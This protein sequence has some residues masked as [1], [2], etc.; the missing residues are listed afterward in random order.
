MS[1]H[2]WND[3]M[4]GIEV[5]TTS[6]DNEKLFAFVQNHKDA[7]AEY[8][9]LD[10]IPTTPDDVYEW[11]DEYEDNMGNIGIA[12]LIGDVIGEM[13]IETTHD[14]Y[15]NDYIGMYAASIF[16][17]DSL[18]GNHAWTSITPEYIEDK[19]RPVVEELYGECP[20]FDEHVIW[21]CG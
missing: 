3:V 18:L 17:W 2:E 4:Y 12:A 19:I 21:N 8:V 1:F 5:P 15:G 9:D 14:E 11:L 7:I 6:I 16:P 10:T 20:K 13:Y